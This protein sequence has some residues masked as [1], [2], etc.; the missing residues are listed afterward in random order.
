MCVKGHN[1]AGMERKK[2][3]L[4]MNNR[5]INNSFGRSSMYNISLAY[6]KRQKKKYRWIKEGKVA[7]NNTMYYYV[8]VNI[9]V[10]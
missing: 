8:P 4:H 6:Q 1:I 3:D 9:T 7:A 5:T 10:L 2:V